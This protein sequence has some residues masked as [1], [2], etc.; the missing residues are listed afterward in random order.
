MRR[1]FPILL[2]ILVAALV[3]E[4]PGVADAQG[5]DRAYCTELSSLY[6]RYIQNSP[7]RR[8]DVEAVKALEDCQKG[9]TAAAV[10]VLERKLRENGFSLPKEFKP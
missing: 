4:L 7:G 10:E 5:D 9:N 1:Q 3:F 6:R 2:A 8:S